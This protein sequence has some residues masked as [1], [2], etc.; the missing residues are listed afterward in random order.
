MRALN[1][2]TV[3]G[4][5]TLTPFLRRERAWMQEPVVMYCRLLML[6]RME[7]SVR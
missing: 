1:S 5:F 3:S 7:L 4:K 6:G 2:G